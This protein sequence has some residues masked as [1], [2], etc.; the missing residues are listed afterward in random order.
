MVPFILNFDEKHI[1][2]GYKFINGY[3]ERDP[4]SKWYVSK[5]LYPN[6]VFDPYI[7]GPCYAIRR[8]IIGDIVKRHF[9]VKTIPLEDVHISYLASD[10]GYYLTHFS[11][12]YPCPYFSC[13]DA[14]IYNIK[15]DMEK[16]EEFL[17]IHKK[18][19]E[20]ED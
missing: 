13:S 14:Y 11:R 3:I 19:Y 2:I 20:T 16:R 9:T 15:R 4:E 1:Y 6:D 7:N 8:N 12:F 17:N 18:D 5:D 10:C